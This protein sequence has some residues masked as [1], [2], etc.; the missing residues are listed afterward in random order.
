M[1]KKV[2]WYEFL[3]INQQINRRKKRILVNIKGFFF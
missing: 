3:S 1:I 2:R